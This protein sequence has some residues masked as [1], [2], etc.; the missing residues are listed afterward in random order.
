MDIYAFRNIGF[1]MQ[2]FAVGLIYGGL[3]ATI[4]GFFLGMEPLILGPF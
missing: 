2:Y 4:Y 1:L 3:P